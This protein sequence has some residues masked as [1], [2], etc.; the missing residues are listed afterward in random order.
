M[1]TGVAWVSAALAAGSLVLHW[2]SGS[3]S[4]PTYTGAGLPGVRWFLFIVVAG[5]LIAVA[6][7]TWRRAHRP[8]KFVGTV[9][10]FVMVL[11]LVILE[12][13]PGLIPG[14]VIAKTVRRN[15]LNVG[16]GPGP[17]LFGVAA[18]ALIIAPLV[19]DVVRLADIPKRLAAIVLGSAA[20]EALLIVL[21]TPTWFSGSAETQSVALQG[22]DLPWIGPLTLLLSFVFPAAFIAYVV[23][24]RWHVLL[25]PAP[26]AWLCALAASIDIAL[27][28][29]AHS[30]RIKGL[31][32]AVTLGNAN[33][34]P[35]IYIAACAVAAVAIGFCIATADGEAA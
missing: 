11:T 10:A 21:R 5:H 33:A 12:V 15:A 18:L 30:I 4:A 2:V 16:A 20:I 19:P 34:A 29:A 28:S 27:A 32:D 31:G 6:L 26:L 23:T 9:E 1:K 35:A 24:G 8:S 3:G 17:W 22:R 14:G 13:L 7:Y 25:I